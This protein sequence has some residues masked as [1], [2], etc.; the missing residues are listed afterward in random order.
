M[1]QYYFQMYL[2][3]LLCALVHLKYGTSQENATREVVDF[4]GL[5]PQLKSESSKRSCRDLL[6]LGRLTCRYYS[7]EHLNKI[8][9]LTFYGIKRLP[10]RALQGFSIQ[11]L[12]LDDPGATVDENAFGGIFKLHELRV[13]R[14]SIQVI[15]AMINELCIYQK[16]QNFFGS[17]KKKGGTYVSSQ[18]CQLS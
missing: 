8:D 14:S 10:A 18:P 6:K 12:A 17:G 15:H 9:K 1:L 11:F 16:Q 5:L 4:Y 13:K 7:E 2:V 3:S